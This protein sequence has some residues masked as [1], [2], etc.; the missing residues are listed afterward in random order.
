MLETAPSHVE[1]ASPSCS[2]RL[3]GRD[4]LQVTAPSRIEYPAPAG[5]GRLS[6]AYG[7][8]M[9]EEFFA[10]R[11]EK[12][13]AEFQAVL[14][15]GAAER[16]LLD[17]VLQPGTVSGDRGLQQLDIALPPAAPGATVV[18]TTIPKTPNLSGGSLTCWTAL[19]V[20]PH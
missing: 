19:R 11:E 14:H 2:T 10:G 15:E 18:L 5:G 3:D 13:A 16:V 20:Q 6:G 12:P 8:K 1:S 4:T 17:R 9:D 7:L